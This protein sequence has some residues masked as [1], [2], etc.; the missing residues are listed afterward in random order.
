MGIFNL[1]PNSHAWLMQ[2]KTHPLLALQ[3]L[4]TR[5]FRSGCTMAE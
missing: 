3:A 2:L 4:Q 5:Y 1:V